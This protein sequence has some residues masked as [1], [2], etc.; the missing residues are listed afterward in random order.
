VASNSDRLERDK[1]L[2]FLDQS[3]PE[4]LTSGF[5]LK[6]V[7]VPRITGQVDTRLSPAPTTMALSGLSLSTMNQLPGAGPVTLQRLKRLVDSLPCYYLELG[8]H[9]AQIPQVI[10]KFLK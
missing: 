3:L 8:T 7:L 1:A 4:K 9:L 2:F 10:L 6:A 5:P